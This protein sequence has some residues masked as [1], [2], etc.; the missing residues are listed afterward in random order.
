MNQFKFLKNKNNFLGIKNSN[1][2]AS[3]VYVVPYGLEKTVSYG[4]GTSLGPEQILKASQQIELYDIELG[5]EPSAI[6]SPKTLEVKEIPSSH[7]S[8]LIKLQNI[9]KLIVSCKKFPIV[10][11]GEHS[12]TPACIKPLLEKN[13]SLTIVQFDQIA[14]RRDLNEQKLQAHSV[15]YSLLLL[16]KLPYLAQP[17]S[18]QL[19]HK[20]VF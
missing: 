19:R 7:V 20:L 9:V 12:I 11:G 13:K 14:F 16:S 6:L 4:K 10:I 2:A 17:L 15:L 3:K 5:I 1:K 8:A 18:L